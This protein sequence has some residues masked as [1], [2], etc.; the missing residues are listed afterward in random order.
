LRLDFELNRAAGSADN[1]IRRVK[2]MPRQTKC[3]NQNCDSHAFEA[4]PIFQ[5]TEN[6]AYI[7][8]CGVCGTA[9]GVINDITPL[10]TAIRNIEVKLTGFKSL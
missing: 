3:P 4:V 5:G 9:I 8:R 2:P 10:K 1:L 6:A 7:V